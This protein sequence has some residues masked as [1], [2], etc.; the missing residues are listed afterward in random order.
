MTNGGREEITE[1][2]GHDNGSPGVHLNQ[3]PPVSV[4]HCTKTIGDVWLGITE[5][6]GAFN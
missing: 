3:G 2:T 5:A 1:G 6:R 4:S